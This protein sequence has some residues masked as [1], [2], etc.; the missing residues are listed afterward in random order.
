MQLQHSSEESVRLLVQRSEPATKRHL[1]R[2]NAALFLGLQQ[3]T[4]FRGCEIY[5]TP[6]PIHKR[7]IYH[8]FG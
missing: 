8:G 1:H 3:L 4:R 6:L 5:S 7:R 2:A